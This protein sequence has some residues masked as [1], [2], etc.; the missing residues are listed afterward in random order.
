[1]YRAD[2]IREKDL[3]FQDIRAAEDELFVD[4]SLGEAEAITIVKEVLVTHRTNVVSSLAYKKDQF[5][6][7]GYEMLTAERAELEKRGLFQTLERSFVNRAAGYIAW[8]AGS[9]TT[10]VFFSE[11]YSFYQKKA[12]EELGIL[13]YPEEFYDDPLIYETIKKMAHCDEK[14]F[15]CHRIGILNQVVMEKEI[16]IREFLHATDWLNE[17]M[18][19]MKGGKRWIL[20]KGLAPKGSKII[21]Y[22]F[23]DVGKDWYEAIREDGNIELVMVVDRDHQRFKTNAVKICPVEAIGEAEYDY[24]LIA[25]NEKSAANSVKDFLRKQGVPTKKILWSDPAERIYE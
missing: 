9:I 22:G 14:E 2:F 24:I 25:I 16:C 6:H 5:W 8:Y 21:L 19:W 15:L 7:C 10:P 18:R 20:P 11:F 4:L 3:R 17:R 23:G 1:M 13:N 12:I